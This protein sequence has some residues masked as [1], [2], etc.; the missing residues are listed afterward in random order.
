[1][2]YVCDYLLITALADENTA[3]EEALVAAH[4]SPTGR[5]RQPG[6]PTTKEWR[7]PHTLGTLVVLTTS[8]PAMGL[9]STRDATRQLLEQFAPSYIGF[10][11]IAGAATD[12][13][14]RPGRIL[15]AE[16]IWYY[17]P[18]KI[19]DG[20]TQHR[21]A[22]HR[23]GSLVLDRLRELDPAVTTKVGL[24][25][26][27]LPP[28]V[29]TVGSGEKVIASSAFRDELR[30][31]GRNVIGYE[32][33]GHSF[34][35][36]VER[37]LSRER[38]FM[39]R[40]VQDNAS[41][42]KDDTYR[43]LAC[44]NAAKYTVA[45][46][47]DSDLTIPTIATEQPDDGRSFSADHEIAFDLGSKLVAVAP[48]SFLELTIARGAA[49]SDC[50]WHAL[51]AEAYWRRSDVN[52]CL[53]WA[54]RA[55]RCAD[56][57]EHA[58]HRDV[59]FRL[60]AWANWKLGD[61]DDALRALTSRM[62][63]VRDM[64]E[65]GRWADLLAGIKRFASGGTNDIAAGW[66]QQ[67]L[68]LKEAAGD[69]VGQAIALH[70]LG[71]LYVEVLDFGRA[72]DYF[73]QLTDF[74]SA[75]TYDGATVSRCYGLL[76]AAWVDLMTG[77]LLHRKTAIERL[78]AVGHQLR[79]PI[80][81]IPSEIPLAARSL[82]FLLH[83][84]AGERR[85]WPDEAAV[86]QWPLLIAAQG[87]V[88]RGESKDRWAREVL[89]VHGTA[90]VAPHAV[91]RLLSVFDTP[92][93]QVSGAASIDRYNTFWPLSEWLRFD[94]TS[95]LG[96]AQFLESVT[97]LYDA[98]VAKLD[99]QPPANRLD[100]V[101]RVA[102]RLHDWANR[103]RDHVLSREVNAIATIARAAT[104]ARNRLVHASPGQ[105]RERESTALRDAAATVIRE[106]MVLA[107]ARWDRHSDDAV[108]RL[109]NM[110]VSLEPFI[111]RLP[112]GR[113][114]VMVGRAEY[115]ENPFAVE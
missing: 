103:A 82:N 57:H 25:S 69:E 40:A 74:A 112:T 39:V 86:R 24:P 49:F 19:V 20:G 2:A 41:V 100:T 28:L 85:R 50:R 107:A 96:C 6:A 77:R 73:N 16:S 105:N 5:V 21:G 63:A 98:V 109:D 18:G 33:E 67:A 12:E 59:S 71:M 11:G 113:L 31:G 84:L 14:T 30:L 108:L 94:G 92:L 4:A 43:T 70:Q 55:L 76:G 45:F 13:G 101:G 64:A 51:V 95:A 60:K 72:R 91:E 81:P 89:R 23:V 114:A 87:A 68:A 42:A 9:E 78:Q 65:R 17:E 111:R 7:L 29:G 93:Q 104:S 102:E 88:V 99:N 10:V 97:R 38:W 61:E 46:I 52:G 34:A 37:A 90:T 36:E 83:V 44:E 80:T 47:L 66:Y 22:I 79:M 56:E 32:M 58:V 115:Y 62:S 15:L 1:M 54:E 27:A 35:D 110:S 53:Q 48:Q 8:L 106:M 3:L 26:S 75:R